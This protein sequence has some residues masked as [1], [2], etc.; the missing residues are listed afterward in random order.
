M[1]HWQRVGDVGGGVT[2]K[3]GPQLKISNVCITASAGL[4]YTPR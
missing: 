2:C 4:G 1:Q 3:T